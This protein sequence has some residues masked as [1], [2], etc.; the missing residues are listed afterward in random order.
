MS[1][2]TQK[3]TKEKLLKAI[4]K[5]EKNPRDN[6]GFLIDIGVGA[7]GAI[8]GGAAASVFGASAI[9]FGLLPVAAPLGVVVGGVALGGMAFVGLKKVLFDGSF[10][11]MWNL[12]LSLSVM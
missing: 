12:V 5:L 6:L 1:V 8:G 9:F 7:A 4:D 3:L 10:K 11:K 2:T